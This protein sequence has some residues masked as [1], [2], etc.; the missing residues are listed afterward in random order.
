MQTT[1]TLHGIEPEQGERG[2]CVLCMFG[3]SSGFAFGVLLAFRVQVWEEAAGASCTYC[4]VELGM[5]ALCTFV[6]LRNANPERQT[7]TGAVCHVPFVDSV[8]P[9][10]YGC[11]RKTLRHTSPPPACMPIR[12]CVHSMH[13]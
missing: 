9:F 3:R 13:A 4:C 6:A 1:H 8:L 7:R 2:G 11:M 10:R 12:A 5:C